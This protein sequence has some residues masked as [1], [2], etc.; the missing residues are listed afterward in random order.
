[1]DGPVTSK[2]GTQ[3]SNLRI[4]LPGDRQMEDDTLRFLEGC[5]LTVR[6]PSARQYIGSISS[7]KGVSVLFQR[8]ADIPGE[9]DAGAVDLAIV[10]Y[11]RYLES[12]DDSGESTVLIQDLGY[13]RCQLVLA[14]PNSWSH[15]RTVQDLAKEAASRP[16]GLRVATKYHRMVGRFL[17]EKGVKGYRS[18]HVSGGVEAAPQMDT[19][20]MVCDIASS[21]G[22][23]RENNLRILD[24]GVIVQSA[25]CLVAN[26]KLLRGNRAK[27]EATK[28]VVE[29]IEARLR[30]EGF[31]HIIANVRG[32]SPESVA[33]LVMK[34]PDLGGMQGPTVATVV[35]KTGEAGWYSVSVV[36]P[37][38]RLTPGVDHLRSIGASGVV[39]FPAYYVFGSASEA[40]KRLEAEL[41]AVRA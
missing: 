4:A 31:Y 29:L 41:T 21:G 34:D 38:A 30:A 17:D 36:V 7:I 18:V 20:D 12:R 13:A 10:G 11:E 33:S 6:R 35:S 40:Y 22:T 9:L 19:A 1:M 2:N 27:L 8:S 5:G 26:K 14:V 28:T 15:V 39:V 32:Q 23:L 24:D 16:G 3:N 37:I 25:S